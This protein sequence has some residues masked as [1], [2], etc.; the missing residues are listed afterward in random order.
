[1]GERAP[2][3]RT[4]VVAS[5]VGLA[6][7]LG[8]GA[9]WLTDDEGVDAGSRGESAKPRVQSEALPGWV[10]P[11]ASPRW[12]MSPTAPV[13]APSSATS[14]PPAMPRVST[15]AFAA[16]PIIVT[17]PQK[18]FDGEV[19][20]LVVSL[21]A[22]AGVDEIGFT[23]QFDPQVL[24]VRAGTEG[25]WA[26]DAG[27]ASR[28]TAEVSEAGDHVHVRSTASGQGRGVPGGSVA[29]LQFQA[30]APGPTSVQII[31]V[32]VKDMAGRSMASALSTQQL[33]ITVDSV[34]PSQ[35]D[36]SPSRA[37][38]VEPQADGGEAGD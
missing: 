15:P 21:G 19:Q 4:L 35:P 5:A 28:F 17:A 16:V 25:D 3:Q 26:A 12:T 13:W 2:R 14:S 30:V 32:V 1:M 10:D 6:I 24:Q 31:D 9:R 7:V 22:N 18:L 34:P 33:A 23:V 38:L 29:I 11:K 37:V 27:A 36:T 20:D 8:I